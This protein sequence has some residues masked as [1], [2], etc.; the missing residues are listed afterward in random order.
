PPNNPLSSIQPSLPITNESS[1]TD[2]I[3]K[4]LS[5]NKV[6]PTSQIA[7]T[8]VATNNEQPPPTIVN[9]KTLRQM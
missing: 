2:D 7:P 1:S 5:T 6:T 3:F 9:T 4:S 8:K